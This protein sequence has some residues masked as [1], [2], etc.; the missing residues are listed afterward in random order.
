[1]WKTPIKISHLGVL[2]VVLLVRVAVS[3]GSSADKRHHDPARPTRTDHKSEKGKKPVSGAE[4]HADDALF[5]SSAV[6]ALSKIH[7]I[8]GQVGELH[9][10]SLSEKVR[11]TQAMLRQVAEIHG[12]AEFVS[13]PF[14]DVPKLKPNHYVIPP[15]L[16]G[17]HDKLV[18]HLRSDRRNS[19]RRF[20]G[21]LL[22]G[23]KGTGKTE[24]TY[25]LSHL[26]EGRARFVSVE[27]SELKRADKPGLA[28][29]DLYRELQ[30][31][32]ERTGLYHALVFD[33]FDELVLDKSQVST[34]KR[35]V[36]SGSHS[37]KRSNTHSVSE[38]SHQFQFDDNGQELLAHL[39]RI[40]GSPEADRVFTIATSNLLDFP[41]PI[42]RDGRL[43]KIQLHPYALNRVSWV[44]Y[45]TLQRCLPIYDSY[46]QIVPQALQVMAAT[47]QRE[48]NGDNQVL[49]QLETAIGEVFANRQTF[50]DYKREVLSQSHSTAWHGELLLEGMKEYQ[51]T[52]S[53]DPSRMLWKKEMA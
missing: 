2:T 12:T 46:R 48:W 29:V 26:T 27:T 34:N 37:E 30:R 36:E 4:A 47:E 22:H 35:R 3:H 11:R 38:E 28:L 40:V 43:E 17:Q 19:A 53:Q 44:E 9:G 7:Q 24:Y 50:A 14:T 23:I 33:E 1:M 15:E 16:R 13:V 20:A 31:E 32:A 8:T 25:L 41:E 42:Y 39:K 6:P 45:G 10:L 52:N 21:L 49:R 5:L 18:E 51:V